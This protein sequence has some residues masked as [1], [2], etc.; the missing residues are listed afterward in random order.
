MFINAS[1][2]DD[3][4]KGIRTS[5]S[6]SLF[7]IALPHFHTASCL[8]PLLQRYYGDHIFSALISI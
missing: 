8:D 2:F 6:R 1:W 7:L 4:L 3:T 5:V